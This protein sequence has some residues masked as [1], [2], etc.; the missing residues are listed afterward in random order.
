MTNLLEGVAVLKCREEKV[1]SLLPYS[2]PIE[3][4]EIYIGLC[5]ILL[6]EK[7]AIP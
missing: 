1:T 6:I 2:S 4:K 5:G 3:G 7:G